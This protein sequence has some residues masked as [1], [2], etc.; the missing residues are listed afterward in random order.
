MRTTMTCLKNRQRKSKDWDS[1]YALMN[2]LKLLN[3]KIDHMQNAVE[4][5]VNSKIDG[6]REDFDLRE[7]RCLEKGAGKNSW[8]IASE[9]QAW[10]SELKNGN[11]WAENSWKAI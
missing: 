9:S 7:A 2:E 1:Y 11:D 5:Q 4:K 8:R 10:A 3:A 6:L